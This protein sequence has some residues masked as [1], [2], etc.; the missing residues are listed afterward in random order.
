MVKSKGSYYI[1]FGC[2]VFIDVENREALNP[3]WKVKPGVVWIL[4]R[5]DGE[6]NIIN[7]LWLSPLGNRIL[8]T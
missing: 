5:R 6:N 2:F 4:V 7:R 3:I 1:V 8:L